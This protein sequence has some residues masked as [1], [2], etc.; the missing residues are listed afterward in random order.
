MKKNELYIYINGVYTPV[1]MDEESF[2]KLEKIV[3]SFKYHSSGS[4]AL[5]GNI[6]ILIDEIRRMRTLLSKH[7]VS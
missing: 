6:P 4:A 3:D 5:L 7:D 2:T 1:P